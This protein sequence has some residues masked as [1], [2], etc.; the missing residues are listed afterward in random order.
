MR[1]VAEVDRLV[2]LDHGKIVSDGPPREVLGRT[3]QLTV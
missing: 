1:S 3:F 2:I